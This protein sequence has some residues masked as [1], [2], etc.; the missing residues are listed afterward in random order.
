M[1]ANL[2]DFRILDLLA[3]E[4]ARR[5]IRRRQL[6]IMDYEPTDPRPET[7]LALEGTITL[8]VGRSG[9]R[10]MTEVR[11]ALATK[12]ARTEAV[13]RKL[14]L[15]YRKRK[16]VPLAKAV[17]TAL[18]QPVFADV[19]H[20]DTVLTESLF[21]PKDMEIAF[22]PFPYNGGALADRGLVLIEH[23]VSEDVEPLD[24]LALRHPPELSKAERAAL[25]SVPP[26]QNSLNVGRSAG[27]HACSV[28]AL[29]LAV[30]AE[31]AIVAVTFAITG[32]ISR[33]HMEHIDDGDIR[34]MGPAK[35]AR[36]LVRMRREFLGTKPIQKKHRH[37]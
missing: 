28:V 12:P 22:V 26:E 29:T 20:G 23:P 7:H 5:P 16:Q 34:K 3:T 10:A 36:E 9:S 31:V 21:V 17:K 18:E 33:A 15:Q 13:A 25:N 6:E 4:A 2:R 37:A 30:V 11:E 19:L 24:V 27:S 1:A 14:Y 35:T 32:G 8:L